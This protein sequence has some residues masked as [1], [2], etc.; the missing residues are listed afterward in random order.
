MQQEQVQFEPT[1]PITQIHEILGHVGVHDDT[2]IHAV[3]TG[4]STRWVFEVDMRQPRLRVLLLNFL[5]KRPLPLR[6]LSVSMAPRN[7]AFYDAK[8]YIEL[9]KDGTLC[10]VRGDEMK[11]PPPRFIVTVDSLLPQE[12][13]AARQG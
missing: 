12:V 10:F 4:N 7:P 5:N 13:R 3:G 6:T 1:K 11:G 9:E 8:V 2:F